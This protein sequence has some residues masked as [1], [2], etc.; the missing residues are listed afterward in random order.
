MF[1]RVA[2]IS[3]TS[4]VEAILDKGLGSFTLEELLEEDDLIQV[5]HISNCSA[6]DLFISATMPVQAVD[7][8]MWLLPTE[9]NRPQVTMSCVS[10]DAFDCR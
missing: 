2:S 6:E 9:Y 7:S 3:H 1:W 10:G 5:S 8:E 4:A